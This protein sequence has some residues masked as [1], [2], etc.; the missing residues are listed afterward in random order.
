M[1]RSIENTLLLQ[2]PEQFKSPSGV[3][4]RSSEEIIRALSGEQCL[5]SGPQADSRKLCQI[6]EQEGFWLPPGS[7]NADDRNKIARDNRNCVTVQ[8]GL[9]ANAHVENS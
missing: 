3:V 2:W 9:G 1:D 5:D 4:Y 6:H 8:W 7:D